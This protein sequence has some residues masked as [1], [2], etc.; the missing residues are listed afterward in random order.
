MKTNSSINGLLISVK[1]TIPCFRARRGVALLRAWR[2]RFTQPEQL[3][4]VQIEFSFRPATFASR[5]H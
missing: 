5:R 3:K 1:R 4:P 2:L